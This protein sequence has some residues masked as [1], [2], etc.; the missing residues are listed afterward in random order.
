MTGTL[1]ASCTSSRNSGLWCFYVF[2][3]DGKGALWCRVINQSLK[4]YVLFSSSSEVGESL[5]FVAFLHC[6]A[7][8]TCSLRDGRGHILENK[9]AGQCNDQMHTCGSLWGKWQWIRNSSGF[10]LSSISLC[11]YVENQG[12]VFGEPRK[13]LEVS[14][15]WGVDRACVPR[16]PRYLGLSTEGG[17]PSR[18][19][20]ISRA[21][22]KWG[23]LKGIYK[24]MDS[25]VCPLGSNCILLALLI[26]I[27]IS[28]YNLQSCVF[29][30]FFF[31]AVFLIN[32]SQALSWPKRHSQ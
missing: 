30:W 12:L 10:G 3:L 11:E 19:A 6:S 18:S 20:Q 15:V 22:G 23:R 29:F 27:V 2:L 14:T 1:E 13:I 9:T 26:C 32:S 21:L 17:L 4:G 31:L 16:T 7:S 28:F 24:Q 25:C 5:L 8:P